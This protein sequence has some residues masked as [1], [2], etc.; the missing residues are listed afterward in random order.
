M[1]MGLLVEGLVGC[2][3]NKKSINKLFQLEQTSM[4]NRSQIDHNSI[5]EAPRS[6]KLNEVASEECRLGSLARFWNQKSP[7]DF[8]KWSKYGTKIDKQTKTNSIHK[9][10]PILID[11]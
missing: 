11:L 7:Q 8:S 3:I 10:I 1:L 2:T 4:K 5:R 9:S 6:R